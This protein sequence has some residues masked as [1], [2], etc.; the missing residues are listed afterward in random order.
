MDEWIIK[1]Q[2][3]VKSLRKNN[4][5]CEQTTGNWWRTDAPIKHNQVFTMPDGTRL[6]LK[7]TTIVF[8]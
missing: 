2:Q 5:I 4:Y 1:D 6:R 3:V 7:G 8:A